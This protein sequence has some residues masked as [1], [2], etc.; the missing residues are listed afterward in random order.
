[1][2]A[3]HSLQMPEV[4][5]C[6]FR[7]LQERWGTTVTQTFL[8]CIELAHRDVFVEVEAKSTKE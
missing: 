5:E 7:A 3:T 2:A 1:M 4:Y 6:M 8:R